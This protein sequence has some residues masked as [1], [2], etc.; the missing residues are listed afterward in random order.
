MEFA[1]VLAKSSAFLLSTMDEVWHRFLSCSDNILLAAAEPL[2]AL[3]WPA[4]TELL[5]DKV[6]STVLLHNAN[7]FLKKRF[8]PSPPSLSSP[9]APSSLWYPFPRPALS[10]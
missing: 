10:H 8:A 4:M 3:M 1:L 5:C 2:F 6:K 7:H 9:S